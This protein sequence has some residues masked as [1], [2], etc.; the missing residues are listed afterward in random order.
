MKYLAAELA[1]VQEARSRGLIKTGKTNES[2]FPADILSKNLQGNEYALKR[3]R[4]LGLR[5]VP[6][7]KPE[8]RRGRRGGRQRGQGRGRPRPLPAPRP[9]CRNV[10]AGALEASR[11]RARLGASQARTIG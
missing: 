8:F 6:P 10:G 9:G 1:V 5:A 2:C 7:A 3:G 4:L 11:P